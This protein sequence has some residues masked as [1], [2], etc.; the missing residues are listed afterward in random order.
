MIVVKTKTSV[1]FINENK[2]ETIVHNL[3]TQE[4]VVEDL[5]RGYSEIIPNVEGVMYYSPHEENNLES[6]IVLE[7]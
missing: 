1:H 7:K 4:A 2:F 6:G 3:D 5:S